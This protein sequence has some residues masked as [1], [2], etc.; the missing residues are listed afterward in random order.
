MAAGNRSLSR[1][2]LLTIA[3]GA[4]G[5][6]VSGTA[7]A[8]ALAR[9]AVAKATRPGKGRTAAFSQPP[10][11][12]VEPLGG[13]DG[14]GE[15]RV[16]ADFDG[17]RFSGLQGK[18]GLD[19]QGRP[20]D[21]PPPTG[22]SFNGAPLH[23]YAPAMPAPR[24]PVMRELALP[25]AS[26]AVQALFGPVRPGSKVG[27]CT[28][29]AIHDLHMGAVPVVLETAAGDRFQ[30]DVLRRDATAGSPAGIATTAAFALYLSN[31]GRGSL[32]TREAAGLGAMALAAALDRQQT[33]APRALLT[34]RQRQNRFPRGG[35]AVPV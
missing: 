4:A 21:L 6:A 28:V 26:V 35:F 13:R 15:T 33:T 10:P 14:A 9:P 34:L 12:G 19:E 30:V 3:T 31:S 23:T 1:R 22:S 18:S 8:S 11:E 20:L 32:R 16:G 24:G 5:L 2:H 29:V 25:T 27:G 17:P 7:L